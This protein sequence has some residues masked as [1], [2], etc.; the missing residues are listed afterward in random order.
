MVTYQ[1]GQRRQS[2]ASTYFVEVSVDVSVGVRMVTNNHRIEAM[3]TSQHER[4]RQTLVSPFCI[5]VSVDVPRLQRTNEAVP[6]DE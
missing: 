6:V 4:R 5:D 2:W 3:I 1:L